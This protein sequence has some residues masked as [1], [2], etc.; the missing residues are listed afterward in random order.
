MAPL[1]LISLLRAQRALRDW[2]CDVTLRRDGDESGFVYFAWNP[3]ERLLKVGWSKDP[4]ARMRSS[5]V[6]QHYLKGMSIPRLLV[7]PCGMQTEQEILSGLHVSTRSTGEV[8]R[9]GASLLAL[10]EDLRGFADACYFHNYAVR[11]ER[12]RHLKAVA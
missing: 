11:R 1:P 9:C 4:V 8:F 10:I 3:L 12:V 2:G 6:V 7:G 5:N